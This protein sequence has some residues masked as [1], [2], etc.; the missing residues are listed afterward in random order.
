[1][2]DDPKE[3]LYNNC[4]TRS[5][6]RLALE[7]RAPPTPQTC[8]YNTRI[9]RGFPDGNLDSRNGGGWL[10][11]SCWKRN[12]VAWGLIKGTHVV[13]FMGFY[14][15]RNRSSQIKRLRA[16]PTFY[17]WLHASS[18]NGNPLHFH[19]MWA[20]PLT[21]T[22]AS[23][24]DLDNAQQSGVKPSRRWWMYIRT[25]LRHFVT[26]RHQQPH[27]APLTLRVKL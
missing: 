9:E 17:S 25:H 5:K 2:E 23:G 22:N 7:I 16:L 24:Y 26:L 3:Y 13:D 8:V 20:E 4:G 14:C 15:Y 12:D 27:D 19:P 1:M 6:P 18:C 11:A 10:K 21:H